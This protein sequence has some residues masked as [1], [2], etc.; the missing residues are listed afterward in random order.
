MDATSTVVLDNGGSTV[1][2]GVVGTHPDPLLVP[3]AVVRSKGDKKNYVGHEYAQCSDY[4][5]LHFRLP[6]E[7]GLVTDW[8]AQKAVWD[9]IF[10]EDLLKLDTQQSSL[11]LTEPYFNLPNLQSTYDQFIFEEYEFKS[12]CR[13]TPASCV[14]YGS[15]FAQPDSPPP[16][17]T[18]ILDCGFSFSHVVPV[19]NGHVQWK[20]VRRVD[21]GGKL[22]TNHL[23]EL[24]SFRQWNMMDQ[25]AVINHVKETCCFVSLDFAKDLERARQ[26]SSKPIE[27]VLP[28]LTQSPHGHLK[29]ANAMDLDNSQVLLM[30]NERFSVPELLFTPSD[31]GL[32]QAGIAHAVAA[33][34]SALP[35]DLRGM[36]WANIGLVGGSTRFS[37]FKQR[38]MLELE[39]LAPTDCEVVI[40][41]SDD[42][43]TAAYHGA[44]A[45]ASSPDF[46]QHVITRAEYLEQGSRR[47]DDDWRPVGEAQT[48]GRGRVRQQDG[49]ER[50]VQNGRA[51]QADDERSTTDGGSGSERSSSSSSEEPER[52]ARGRRK[53]LKGESSRTQQ[54]TQPS[55]PVR[56]RG[57]PPKHAGPT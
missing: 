38:L 51:R 20:A 21:V 2:A 52:P 27:Y 22:L 55:G 41:E 11:L 26:G 8:D 33:S 6:L 4:S 39:R 40:Y 19:I 3:N 32:E 5:S 28:D 35:E 13:R 30:G 49:R 16:E 23:K 37:G 1:K 29:S 56:R 12:Y 9:V 53:S 18:L 7:K 50:Q 45:F 17:C 24:V 48:P 14:P 42:P 44:Y 36:F 57:R 54:G 34:I 25:T 31:I 10:S 15:L 47:H 46:P 43:T